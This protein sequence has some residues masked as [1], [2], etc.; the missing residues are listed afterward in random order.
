MRRLR[1]CQR[2]IAVTDNAAA[3][4]R[5][6]WQVRQDRARGVGLHP[7][8]RGRNA[9]RLGRKRPDRVETLDGLRGGMLDILGEVLLDQQ[10][11][12]SR[13]YGSTRDLPAPDGGAAGRKGGLMTGCLYDRG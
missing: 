10:K 7:Q 6:V 11:A 2:E 9:R 8:I 3:F 12:G 4:G 1:V 5:S 13:D